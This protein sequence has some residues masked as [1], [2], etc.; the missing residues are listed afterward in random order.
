MNPLKA[1]IAMGIID[2]VRNATRP[3]QRKVPKWLVKRVK[4]MHDSEYAYSRPHYREAMRD[5]MDLID[6][7]GTAE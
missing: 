3:Q 1:K 7:G 6:E 4:E 2:I 5:V